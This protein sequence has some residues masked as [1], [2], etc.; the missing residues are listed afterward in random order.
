MELTNIKLQR[1]STLVREGRVKAGKVAGKNV[2]FGPL[3]K[4]LSAATSKAEDP[5]KVEDGTGRGRGR[6]RLDPQVGRIKRKFEG[7][8][9][10]SA[11]PKEDEQQHGK[12]PDL[13]LDPGKE[14]NE[15]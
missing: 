15:V 10:A 6:P 11:S 9:E 5:G 13:G 3:E 1:K 12:D 8:G 4:W 7:S 14:K 2:G